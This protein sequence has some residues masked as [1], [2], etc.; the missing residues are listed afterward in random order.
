MDEVYGDVV[1]CLPVGEVG[2]R[3]ANGEVRVSLAVSET[4]VFARMTVDTDFDTAR[5]MVEGE[6]SVL[7]V[8]SDGGDDD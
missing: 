8:V 7:V 2:I 1:A 5:R 3:V 6:V 4:D